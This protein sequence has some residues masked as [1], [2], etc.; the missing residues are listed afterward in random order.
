MINPPFRPSDSFCPGDNVNEQMAES[1]ESAEMTT[2]MKELDFAMPEPTQN[3]YSRVEERGQAVVVAPFSSPF[4]AGPVS[5]DRGSLAFFGIEFPAAARDVVDE[6]I[7]PSPSE[8]N[9]P[10]KIPG[11]QQ[12]YEK[13]FKILLLGIVVVVIALLA[14][15]MLLVKLLPRI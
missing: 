14:G 3:G 12:D 8:E 13:S 10:P 15:A 1:R 7:Q 11:I 5:S 4:A 2:H 9:R 6:G